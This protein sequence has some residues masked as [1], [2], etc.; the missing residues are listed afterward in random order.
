[1]QSAP[2]VAFG[3]ANLIPAA[4]AKTTDVTGL[5]AAGT[6]V[7]ANDTFR[8][9]AGDGTPVALFLV[10]GTNGSNFDAKNVLFADQGADF[11]PVTAA[12][13]VAAGGPS[14]I[15]EIDLTGEAASFR[16]QQLVSQAITM[17]DGSMGDVTLMAPGGSPA[18]ITAPRIV[19][20]IDVTNGSIS[21][22]IQ[23]TA[24][25]FGRRITNAAGQV[26]GVTFVRAGAGGLTGTGRI[27][28]AADLVS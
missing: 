14:I 24:G 11:S 23:T 13:R 28:S 1:L 2:A 20:N 18:N 10:T 6:T 4:N 17:L 21:G 25:D 15:Q 8:V 27:I 3:F 9:F 16:T 12:V 5:F 26:T 22:T 19:G 7:Q